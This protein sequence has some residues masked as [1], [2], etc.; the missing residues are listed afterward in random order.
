MLMDTI[1]MLDSSSEIKKQD[2]VT[3]WLGAALYDLAGSTLTIP[4]N[5]AIIFRFI[6]NRPFKLPIGLVNSYSECTIAPTGNVTYSIMINN[7]IVG[8]INYA[9]GTYIATFTFP[10]E[11]QLVTGDILTI[12][13]PSTVDATHND[14]GWTFA[15]SLL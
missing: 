4:I 10:V 8:T 3:K 1:R 6:V 15:G 5:N 11:K 14:F 12:I 2:G 7:I 13:A 9:L